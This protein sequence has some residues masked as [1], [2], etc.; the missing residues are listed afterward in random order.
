[1]QSR[2][3]AAAGW[4]SR[5]AENVAATLLIVMFFVFLLQVVFRYL[6]NLPTGWAN[7]LT[8]ICWLWL[9]PFGAAFVVSEESEIRLD[10][11]YSATSPGLRRI[12]Q[13]VCAVTLVGLF[14]V[15]LPAVIDYVGFM[16]VQKTAYL[17]IRFDWLFSIY[18][19]FAVAM[20]VRYIWLGY[21]AI[22]GSERAAR[23]VTNLESGV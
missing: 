17:K 12:M 3:T 22:W 4:L 7:E 15:S 2:L 19:V 8:V 14:A 5:R 16:K 1:M 6:L 21:R 11:I 13:L 9:V 10:L 20:I 23:D 18:V